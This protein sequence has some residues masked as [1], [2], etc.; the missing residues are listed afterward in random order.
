MSE[1]Q[2]RLQQAD[3]GQD[4][5][6]ALGKTDGVFLLVTDFNFDYE[7]KFEYQNMNR[8]RIGKFA[9]GTGVPEGV[10]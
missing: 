8:W 9:G 4:L 3:L 2:S 10:E 6:A 1:S 7:I 5:L